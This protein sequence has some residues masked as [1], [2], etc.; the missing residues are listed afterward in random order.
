LP[1]GAEAHAEIRAL[2]AIDDFDSNLSRE[3]LVGTLTEEH[4]AG[5][6]AAEH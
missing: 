6:T 5:A 1:L 3:L 4:G 2:R